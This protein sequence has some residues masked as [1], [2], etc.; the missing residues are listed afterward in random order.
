MK[1]R[2]AVALIILA[3]AA[4]ALLASYQ[5]KPFEMR[6]DAQSP[7]AWP[8]YAAA[9]TEPEAISLDRAIRICRVTFFVSPEL[10]K[11][12]FDAVPKEQ[13]QSAAALCIAYRQG[14]QDMLAAARQ[15]EP[16]T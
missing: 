16:R 10:G 13:K 4:C 3:I 12:M 9:R 5:H 2:A 15:P 1:L 11:A 6:I 8:K 14:A 7:G